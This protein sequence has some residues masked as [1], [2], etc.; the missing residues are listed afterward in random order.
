MNKG[1]LLCNN[2]INVKEKMND[3]TDKSLSNKQSH[4]NESSKPDSFKKKR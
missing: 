3:D 1:G 4:S 2:K